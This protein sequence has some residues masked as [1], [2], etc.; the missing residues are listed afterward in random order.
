MKQNSNI[1][2]DTYRKNKRR[3]VFITV[4]NALNTAGY[5]KIDGKDCIDF[6]KDNKPRVNVEICPACGKLLADEDAVGGHVIEFLPPSPRVYITPIHD[7]C[8][9]KRGE[10][11]YFKVK[12]GNLVQVPPI[13]EQEI[14]AMRENNEEIKK[15]TEEY[16]AATI[17]PIKRLMNKPNPLGNV[18]T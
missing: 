12:L 8:N 5:D 13:D 14:L 2:L 10:L 9:K 11:P 16:K 17:R 6:W 15:K 1:Y 7:A 18:N 4:C 3:P